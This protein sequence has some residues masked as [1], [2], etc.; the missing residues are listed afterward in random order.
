MFFQVFIFLNESPKTQQGQII[1][2]LNEK[3]G[4]HSLCNVGFNF[5]QFDKSIPARNLT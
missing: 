4:W 2:T 3:H 5:L 1:N